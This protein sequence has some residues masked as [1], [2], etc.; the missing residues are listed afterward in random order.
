MRKF[1]AVFPTWNAVR[2]ELI[3]FVAVYGD[4]VIWHMR[5]PKLNLQCLIC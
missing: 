2:S 4:R 3:F 1:Y 5:V